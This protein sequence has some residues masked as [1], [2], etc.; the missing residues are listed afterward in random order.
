MHSVAILA[1]Q[2]HFCQ[3]KLTIIFYGGNN[4]PFYYFVTTE[5]KEQIKFSSQYCSVHPINLFT[6]THVT[7]ATD[8]IYVR[9]HNRTFYAGSFKHVSRRELLSPVD[10]QIQFRIIQLRIIHAA[11]EARAALFALIV[12]RRS[13]NT[14]AGVYCRFSIG[15]PD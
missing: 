1:T 8:F 10:S 2:D 11:G 14:T 13:Y 3:F 4:R 7:F 12:S 5:L 9:L 15:T 6:F